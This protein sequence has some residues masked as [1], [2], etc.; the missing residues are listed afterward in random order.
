MGL[1]DTRC[2]EVLGF[3]VMKQ[4]AYDPAL[5]NLGP[6][7]QP[8]VDIGFLPSFSITITR[9]LRLGRLQGKELHSSHGPGGWQGKNRELYLSNVLLALIHSEKA[10]PWSNLGNELIRKR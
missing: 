7:R 2:W 10:E 3:P 8:D 9:Y 6:E 4:R 5:E 1:E